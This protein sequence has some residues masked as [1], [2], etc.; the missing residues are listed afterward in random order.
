[1]PC[2]RRC[3]LPPPT[4][5]LSFRPISYCVA[6]F[7][8]VGRLSTFY[9]IF[10][11]SVHLSLPLLR[12][13]PFVNAFLRFLSEESSLPS[14]VVRLD[15]LPI[16]PFSLP[17]LQEASPD[18]PRSF[19]IA[20]LVVPRLSPSPTAPFR[21]SPFF[22]LPCRSRRLSFLTSLRSCCFPMRPELSL[23]PKRAHASS[24]L[25]SSLCPFCP[26]LSVR[27]LGTS[28]PLHQENC[29]S[30]GA[31][32]ADYPSIVLHPDSFDKGV[33]IASLSRKGGVRQCELSFSANW[34]VQPSPYF[35]L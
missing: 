2:P 21:L 16:V 6:N 7:L 3:T 11:P 30:L 12:M 28:L 23:I 5:R 13:A 26:N 33:R 1:L 27:S 9:S 32:S 19:L 31:A 35:P 17:T 22:V 14:Q 20:F 8:V 18:P 29:V 34:R 25:L 10:G 15:T 4:K 24:P